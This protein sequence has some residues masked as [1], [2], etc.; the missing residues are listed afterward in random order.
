MDATAVYAMASW[1]LAELVRIFHGISTK[2]AQ[3]TVDALVERK[4]SL[5]WEVEQIKRVL[6]PSMDKDDQTL[7]LLYSK[8]AWVSEQD[9]IAW[10][11]YSNATKFRTKILRILHKA[12]LIEYDE[13]QHRARISPLGSAHVE[14][15]IIKTRT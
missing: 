3:E 10:V 5:V 11:E 9:L 14:Q 15:K 4:I 7:L 6:D 12:R 13:Q 1:T 8:P 2:E